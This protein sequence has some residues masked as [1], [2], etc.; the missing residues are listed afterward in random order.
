MVYY[1]AIIVDWCQLVNWFCRNYVMGTSFFL[2][3]FILFLLILSCKSYLP[4]PIGQMMDLLLIHNEITV[5]CAFLFA[6]LNRTAKCAAIYWWIL[7][8]NIT[9]ILLRH[10]RTLEVN[11]TK[12]YIPVVKSA[13]KESPVISPLARSPNGRG[14]VVLSAQN[15]KFPQCFIILYHFYRTMANTG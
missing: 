6:F 2:H 13:Y 3:S 1:T 8:L 7:S 10:L 9:I 4:P 14:H 11:F 15:A 5:H 12:R